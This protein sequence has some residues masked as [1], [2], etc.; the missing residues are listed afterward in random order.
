MSCVPIPLVVQK[1]LIDVQ[2]GRVIFKPGKA[3]IVSLICPIG[4]VSE[5][6]KNASLRSLFLT[7]RDGDGKEGP[8]GVVTANLRRVR[9]SDGAVESLSNSLVSSNSTNAPNSGPKGWATHQSATTNSNIA[10]GFEFDKFYYYVHI[11]MKRDDSAVPLAVLGVFL[12]N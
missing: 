5:K 6:M 12:I 9:Q 11:T 2:S 3:G 10:Q 8:G 1:D 7:Y 4:T